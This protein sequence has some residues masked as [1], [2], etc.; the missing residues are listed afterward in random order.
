MNAPGNKNPCP[1]DVGIK[2]R[3]YAQSGSPLRMKHNPTVPSKQNDIPKI[4]GALSLFEYVIQ[5]P[6]KTPNVDPAIEGTMRRRPELVA[7]SKRTAWKK[8]GMLKRTPLMRIAPMKFEKMMLARGV[9]VMIFKGM[10]GS[11]TMV[12]T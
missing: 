11:G 8:R 12:S 5:K 4:R 1:M 10:M 9:D 7:D 2:N 6:V 3:T